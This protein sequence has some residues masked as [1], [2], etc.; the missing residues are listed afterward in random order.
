MS[1]LNLAVSKVSV[2]PRKTLHVAAG[3]KALNFLNSLAGFVLKGL[4]YEVTIKCN[5]ANSELR[6]FAWSLKRVY[7]FVT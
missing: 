3:H 1:I 4:Y 5:K 6:C 2:D 7:I